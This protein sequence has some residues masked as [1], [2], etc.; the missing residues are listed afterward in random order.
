[1]SDK[2]AYRGPAI[3]DRRVVWSGNLPIKVY[4]LGNFPAD[5][6]P[7]LEYFDSLLGRYGFENNHV[8]G[9]AFLYGYTKD[10]HKVKGADIEVVRTWEGNPMIDSW[11]IEDH[12]PATREEGIMCRAESIIMGRESELMVLAKDLDDYLNRWVEVGGD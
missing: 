12:R 11:T 8:V 10:G 4:T 6:M 5:E 3:V 7:A 2:P 1:M 9:V